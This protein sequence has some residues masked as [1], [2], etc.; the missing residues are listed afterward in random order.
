MR[1]QRE[2]F[3][4]LKKEMPNE[5][6][7]PYV[8]GIGDLT[9]DIVTS[10]RSFPINANQFYPTPELYQNPGGRC[11][12][13]IELSR[14]QIHAI[15]LDTIGTDEWGDFL[16]ST[17]K[18]EG[19]D[20]SLVQKS[21][22]TCRSIVL[23]DPYGNHSFIGKFGSNAPYQFQENCYSTISG[24]SAVFASG[25]NFQNLNSENLAIEI[26]EKAKKIGVI[27]GFDTGPLFHFLDEN[28][29]TKIYNLCSHLFLTKE[30]LNSLGIKKISKF[31]DYGIE[32]VVVKMGMKGCKIFTN[33]NEK[34]SIHGLKVPVTDT[35]AAGDCFDAGFIVGLIK[36]L[37]LMLCATLANC[38]GAATVK[39]LGGG[40]NVPTLEEVL[41]VAKEFKIC[42]DQFNL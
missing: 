2:L 11:N 4:L 16:C 31:F 30:E 5:H 41:N 33:K 34:F 14:L 39:K 10:I 7:K 38:V 6:H 8:V 42:A 32:V 23:S 36:G 3:N 22:E 40:V 27:R 19:I 37:P 29:K 26:L 13:L 15:A 1:Q 28:K 17:L 35:T 25:Y 12:F 21:E 18:N 20:L 24:A 9:L